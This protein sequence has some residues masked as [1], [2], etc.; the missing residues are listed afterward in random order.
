M[1]E[2]S[3]RSASSYLNASGGVSRTADLGG[4]VHYVDFGGAKGAPRLVLVHGLGGSHLNW[5]LLAP[6]LAAA[7]RVLAVDLIGFGLTHPEGRAAT[8]QTNAAL[9]DRFV[10]EVAGAPAILV[11]NSMGGMVSIMEAAAHSDAVAGLVLIDPVLPLVRG[12]R[13]DRLVLTMFLAYALPGIG[14]RYL[15]RHR[16]AVPPR[17]LVQQVLDVSCADPTRIPKELV[18]AAV[19]LAEERAAVEGL[20]AAFLSATRSLLWVSAKRERYWAAMRAVA[21][22]VLLLHGEQDRLVSVR[23]AREAAARNP[24][25]RFEV[26]PDAGHVPQLEVPDAVAARML[27]WLGSQA[28]SAARRAAEP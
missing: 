3:Q 26:F 27:D 14:E 16:A 5:C 21:A 7:A 20:D 9:L 25:W 22:P 12:V 10:R 1:A 6:R 23:S 15:A 4:P 24:G 19:A 28:A 17:Q 8:V 2:V 13:P 11:G 18:A